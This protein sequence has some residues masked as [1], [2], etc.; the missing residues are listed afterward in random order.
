MNGFD[1]R[2]ALEQLETTKYDVVIIGGGITGAGILLDAVRQGLKAVL[3]EKRDYAWGTSSRSTKLIHGG[4]RY[5]KQFEVGLVRET[6]KERA[7]VYKNAP[8][9]V[10]P[11]RMLLPIIKGGQL[12]QFTSR[13]GLWVYDWLA[14]VAADERRRMLDVEETMREE[15]LLKKEDLLGGGLYY[16]YRTDDARL[17]I[18]VIKTAI[19][20]GGQ[21]INHIKV[22]D[23]LYKKEKVNGVVA[24][25][26]WGKRYKV[27]ARTVINAAGP[28]VDEVREMENLGLGKKRLQLTKGVHLVVP[29]HKLPVRQACY[30]DVPGDQ[31]MVFA[32]PREGI[33]YFGTTDT[34][35]S[36]EIDR[37]TVTVEDIAYLVGAVNNT[38][39]GVQIK[40]EDLISAWV[41]LRPL[42]HAE[43]KSPSD[44]SR[45]DEIF[46]SDSG[47]ISIAGGKL[48]GYR[49][50]AERAVDKALEQLDKKRNE[51]A[52]TQKLKLFGG[53]FKA[54]NR[55]LVRTEI[56]DKYRHLALRDSDMSYLFDRW[57]MEAEEILRQTQRVHLAGLEVREA[58]VRAM[59]RYT[60]LKEMAMTLSDFFVRRT[61]DIYFNPDLVVVNLDWVASELMRFYRW[62]EEDM[63]WQ[64]EE[65]MEEMKVLESSK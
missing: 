19:D 5:L 2:L 65:L 47:L 33:T 17:T 40:R 1:R 56:W 59:V 45:K 54:K 64:R 49:M 8:H 32:I 15:P 38:F 26:K 52:S 34:M 60:C 11:V 24:K 51:E 7:R 3:L 39:E 44:L 48:T 25:D 57:G 21:A 50:M 29:Y 63:E 46:M 23:F 43:G 37:P 13:V 62:S 4:L 12:G 20:L 18:E 10:H 28:W 27:K 6:G 35:Y 36:D 42:I 58:L 31:R 30:F 53:R 9:I 55:A 16:E 41:G 61:G 14:D 22:E